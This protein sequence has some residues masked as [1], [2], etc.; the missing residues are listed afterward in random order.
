MEVLHTAK[1]VSLLLAGIFCLY[2]APVEI[3]DAELVAAALT[4]YDE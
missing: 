4:S 3:V 1:I 2:P